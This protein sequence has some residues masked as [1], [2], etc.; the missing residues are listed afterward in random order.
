MLVNYVMLLLCYHLL[1]GGAVS[2]FTPTT[3]SAQDVPPGQCANQY[4]PLHDKQL[5]EILQ[6][7]KQRIPNRQTTSNYSSCKSILDD[8]PS[9][10]SGYYNITTT[11]GTA[12]QVYCDMEGTHCGGEGGWTRVTYV[13]MT[14]AGA[15]CPQGLEQM[16]FSGS[17]YCGRFSTGSGCV[18]AILNTPFS[19][20]HVCGRAAGY[21]HY[22]PGA[23]S[24]SSASIDG[25][26][27]DGLSIMYG[28]PRRHIWTYTAGYA[29]SLNSVSIYCPC[30]SG[31]TFPVPSYVGSNYYCESGNN[32]PICKNMLFSNDVLWDGQQC[33]GLELPCC[34]H[35]NM[36]WFIKPLNENTTEDIELRACA[37]NFGC[38]GSVAIFLIEI[39]VR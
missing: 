5:I 37:Q 8:N 19:Y 26:F 34:T 24:S 9:A 14:Q 16:L 20:R 6:Q 18:S 22:A 38:D 10:P 11:N 39:Y 1:L 12:V 23:F 32:V 15:A 31:S 7:V 21:Q 33:G 3:Y 27:F 2:E 29:D 28:N 17:P 4:N 36:P 30:N 35:P 13:N 25:A